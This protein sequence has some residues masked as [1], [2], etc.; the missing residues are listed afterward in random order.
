MA[1]IQPFKGLRYNTKKI[2]LEDIITEPY[3]RITP[4]MQED[5]YQRSPYNVVRII[6]G[7]ED[8]PGHPEKD[9]Y[10]RAKIYLDEWERKGIFIR[11]GK[12]ALYLYE[13]EFEVKGEVKK[14]L[15]LIARVKLEEFSSK[16][17]L[18]HEKTFPKHKEDRL[19]LLKAT[20]NNTEQIF[21]LYTDDD[22][23]VQRA[24]AKALRKA[25]LGAEVRDEDKFLHR[26]R[27]I[28]D[29]KDIQNIQKAM[30]DKILI[31]ADGHHRYE[32]SLNYQREMIAETKKVKGDEP[33]QYVMMTLFD[34]KDPGLV[35]L[36]TYRL[37]KNLEKLTEANFKKLYV[38]NFEIS[39][40]P[41][42]GLPDQ[43]TLDGVLNRVNKERH[44]FAAYL[45]QVK[46]FFIFH[47]KDEGI[48]DKE[49]KEEK[50][51]VWKRLDV[52][53][54]HSL[55]IDKLQALTNQ[56]FLLEN[57]VSYI[58]NLEEGLELVRKGEF[59]VIFLLKPASL[60]EIR[61]IV[62]SGELMPHKSTDFFPKLK[63][64]LVMN[65]LDD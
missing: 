37:V 1:E 2:R 34:I 6:L 53:I 47:L 13:Q 3:D 10:Q 12:K 61:E 54:L 62:E 49:I 38:Q 9:K 52:A 15:G 63:S 11:E 29:K 59:Q 39:E 22:K 27:V 32:T 21:L 46:K 16:R 64:G 30:S 45:G 31:I 55:L 23:R 28:K 17:V 33:F 24:I 19:R 58:R 50:P 4:V 35:I 56:P 65:P 60:Q 14:R 57:N 7:K 25:E 5:Y 36:P 42:V 43:T 44:T 20:K 48:L 41:W 8:E 26:L 51:Q 40:V 18:P